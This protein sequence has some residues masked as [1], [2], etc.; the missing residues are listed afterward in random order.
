MDNMD[1][2]KDLL[3]SLAER[4]TKSPVGPGT[5]RRRVHSTSEGLQ[6]TA[7][8]DIE[9][10]AKVYSEGEIDAVLTELEKEFFPDLGVSRTLTS[11]RLSRFITEGGPWVDE[12]FPGVRFIYDVGKP[13]VAQIDADVAKRS[14]ETYFPSG[15]KKTTSG[16][17]EAG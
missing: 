2:L 5:G 8:I 14:Q 9:K 11:I 1:R 10:L 4:F 3:Y 13:I 15:E 16:G 6:I 7:E 12:S 17:G